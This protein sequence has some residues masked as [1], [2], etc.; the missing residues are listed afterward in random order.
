MMKNIET[1]ARLFSMPVF[2]LPV[3]Q[4]GYRPEDI[5]MWALSQFENN[6]AFLLFQ[7]FKSFGFAA[8]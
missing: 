3:C 7:K 4:A 2:F 6:S 8:V 5:P 1:L